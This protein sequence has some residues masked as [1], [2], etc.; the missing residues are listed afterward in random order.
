[1]EK[2]AAPTVFPK[3]PTE[4]GIHLAY[5]RRDVDE[6]KKQNEASSRDIQ[7]ALKELVD[8][9]PTRKEFDELKNEVSKK[10]DSSDKQNEIIEGL[11]GDRKWAIG[12][13]TVLI[14]LQGALIL[15]AK[16][17]IQN[18]VRDT[19]SAYNIKVEN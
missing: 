9:T 12:A 7:A 6:M 19:L 16:L 17:Y 15:L 10:A 2:E 13:L 18:V 5:I 14:F 3:N 1:M 11:V 4:M 8:R